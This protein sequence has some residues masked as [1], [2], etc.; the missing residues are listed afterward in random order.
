MTLMSVAVV[1]LILA[2]A[3]GGMRMMQRTTGCTLDMPSKR[4]PGDNGRP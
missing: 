2:V 4:T 1:L 3:F